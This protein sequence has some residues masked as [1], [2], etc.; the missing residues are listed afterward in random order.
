MSHQVYI[1]C[2]ILAALVAAFG[3]LGVAV[4]DT[5]PNMTHYTILVVGLVLTALFNAGCAYRHMHLG[6]RKF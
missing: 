3:A 1:L 4:S 5:V 2:H 6:I